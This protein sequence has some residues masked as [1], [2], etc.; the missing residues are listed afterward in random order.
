MN[1]DENLPYSPK[2]DVS[3]FNKKLYELN[4]IKNKF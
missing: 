4:Y 3:I 1:K 2:A